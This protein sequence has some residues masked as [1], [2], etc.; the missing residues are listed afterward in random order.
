MTGQSGS[1]IEALH[2]FVK[3]FEEQSGRFMRLFRML[4]VAYLAYAALAMFL[5]IFVLGRPFSGLLFAVLVPGFALWAWHGSRKKRLHMLTRAGAL[6]TL[7]NMVGLSYETKTSHARARA[8][9]GREFGVVK[10][11]NIS[12]NDSLSGTL[13]DLIFTVDSIE[14]TDDD[15]DGGQRERFRGLVFGLE[16]RVGDLSSLVIRRAK[17]EFS[18]KVGAVFGKAPPLEHRWD[19]EMRVGADPPLAVFYEN[20]E[21]LEHRLDRVAQAFDQTKLLFRFQVGIQGLVQE[22]PR[23]LIFMDSSVQW[24][25]VRDLEGDSAELTKELKRILYEFSLPVKL[26]EIWAKA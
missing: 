26:V 8:E 24:F 1:E 25:M 5:G 3:R 14:M 11:K 22:G 9:R 16:P 7:S 20:A 17:S 21:G 23:L 2:G 12:V 13:G 18:R 6:P 10:G 4:L 19:K 15:G